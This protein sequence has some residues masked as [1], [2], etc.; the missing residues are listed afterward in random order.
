MAMEKSKCFK[1]KLI[2]ESDEELLNNTFPFYVIFAIEMF[3]IAI[4]QGEFN[5]LSIML[6][7]IGVSI[8]CI[9]AYKI[10]KNHG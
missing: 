6:L 8:A 3:F 5:W 2:M 7:I 1:A 9:T 4:L 10:G